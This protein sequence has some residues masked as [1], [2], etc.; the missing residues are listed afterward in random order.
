MRKI[1]SLI[2]CLVSL[3]CHGQVIIEG[4]IHDDSGEPLDLVFVSVLNPQD[5]TVMS[6]ATTN[7]KG[8][9][10]VT[11]KNSELSKLLVRVSG[12]NVER[13]FRLL[14]NRS[15]HL[16]WTC[17]ERSTVLRELSVKAQKL[18]GSKDTLNYLVAAYAQ[19]HDV[20]IGD[21]LKRLPGITVEANG[22]V[23]YQGVPISRFYIENMDVLQGRYGIATQGIKAEDVASVQ[24]LEHHQH[25]KALNDQ[26]PPEAAAINLKLKEEKKGTWTKLL[27]L[28]AGANDRF[29]WQANAN[30]MFFGKKQQHV[31]VYDTQSDGEGSDMLSVHYGGADLS[32]KTVTSVNTAPASPIGNSQRHNYHQIAANNLWKTSESQEMHADVN[33]RH[34]LVKSEAH[35][36]TTYMLPDQSTRVLKEDLLS[37]DRYDEAR[38]VLT[39]EENADRNYLLNRLDLAGKWNNATSLA[40]IRQTGKR[41][42]L[43]MADNLKWVHRNEKGRGV[44]IT[45]DNAYTHTPQQLAITP[46]AFADL[47]N[48]SLSYAQTLQTATVSHLTSAAKVGM[49]SNIRRK[50]FT[51]TPLGYVKADHIGIESLLTGGSTALGG[52][53]R[54]THLDAGVSLQARYTLRQFFFVLSLPASVQ[55]TLLGGTSHNASNRAR[56]YFMPAAQFNWRMH[57]NWV[58]SGNA[59]YNEKT[60]PWSNLYTAY[61]MRNHTTMDRYAGDVYDSRVTQGQ[62]KLDY[63]QILN[64][65]FSW[66]EFSGSRNYSGITYGSYINEQGYSEMQM[67]HQPHS[68]RNLQLRGNLR[69]D[70]DW[71]NLSM[72]VTGTWARGASQ[73]L[74]QDVLTR[75]HSTQYAVDWKFGIKPTKWIDLGYNCGWSRYESHTQGGVSSRPVVKWTNQAT[76]STTIVDKHLW[77][78][79]HASHEYNNLLDNRNYEYLGAHL[80]YR[81]KKMDFKLQADNLLN[82]RHYYQMA[83]SDLTEHYT[84]YHLRPMTIMLSTTIN[85]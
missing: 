24:V 23:R 14:D 70:L 59:A 27:T 47:L 39:W 85:L 56:P 64:Q 68:S 84:D 42:T 17:K 66:I 61:L 20:T 4:S 62:V 37:R 54:Y 30:A 40:T 8:A 67:V 41:H 73:Y 71:K 28:G 46:G 2:F 51:L 32:G 5:S 18:W 7:E 26:M 34:N 44:E 79:L 80:R 69:K 29:A 58:A 72:E 49:V 25:V 57:D 45:F 21:V 15:Q 55:A 63:K 35:A 33:Y 74:R 77:L 16:D 76:V 52:D 75:Y 12:F 78:T 11:V 3:L 65:F 38:M 31:M 53:M 19:G 48:D 9:Y 83:I 6:Y 60:T 10:H 22:T 36:T 81:V 43:G 50:R 13:E 82:T 1:V